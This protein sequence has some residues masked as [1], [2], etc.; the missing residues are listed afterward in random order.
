VASCA[1]CGRFIPTTMI[2]SPHTVSTI[3]TNGP[4]TSG[5]VWSEPWTCRRSAP[6][7]G[8]PHHH[9]PIAVLW[10][11]ATS[12]AR[13]QHRTTKPSLGYRSPGLLSQRIT[14]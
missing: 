12:T 7:C 11:L 2:S 3:P 10:T 13:V 8:H 1:H 5:N 9:F 6:G 14:T 4:I